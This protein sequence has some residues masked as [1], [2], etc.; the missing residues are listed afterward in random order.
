MIEFAA[1]TRIESE[2][3]MIPNNG[4]EEKKKT[5]DY[6]YS[7]NE[8]ET[9]MMKFGLSMREIWSIPGKKKFTLGEP[10]AYFV[11]KKHQ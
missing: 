2:I 1:P 9:T 11:A 8:T 6:I 5:V 10:R 7:V 4:A 3:T